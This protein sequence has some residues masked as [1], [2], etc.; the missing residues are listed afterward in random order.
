MEALSLLRAKF[1]CQFRLPA[2]FY[3]IHTLKVPAGYEGDTIT[4]T[5]AP[6][7]GGELSVTLTKN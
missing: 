4:I 6:V 3:E 2:D 5:E 7:G 1:V